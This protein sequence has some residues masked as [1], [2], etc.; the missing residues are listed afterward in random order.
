MAVGIA[1]AGVA[2]KPRGDFRAEAATNAVISLAR[3]EYESL[4]IVVA[5]RGDKPLTGVKVEL[6]DNMGLFAAS[7]V[8]VSVM[9]YVR[10]NEPAAYM[11]RDFDGKVRWPERTWYPD[12]ILDFKACA[13]VEKGDVQSFW[14]RVKCPAGQ[15]AGTY[16]GTLRVSNAD[17]GSLAVPFTVRIRDFD[18]PL[19]SPLDMA[20]CFNPRYFGV[21]S[22]EVRQNPEAP[23]NIWKRHKIAWCDF[24]SEYFITIDDIYLKGTPD[25]DMLERL[26]ARGRLGRFN[27]GY[28]CGFGPGRKAKSDWMGKGRGLRLKAVAEEAKRRGLLDYA[29]FYG[30]DESPKK[31]WPNQARGASA[32]KEMFPHI[33]FLTTIRD[34]SCGTDSILGDVDSFVPN[35]EFWNVTK[36]TEGRRA[37][38]KVWWYICSDPKAPGPNVFVECP[39]VEARLLMGALTQRFKPDG[40]L[41]YALALWRCQKPITTGPFT[42]WLARNREWY[43]GDG[44]MTYCGPD[45]TPIASQHLE[46]FRDG[47]ED[48]W[49]CRILERC[50]AE[51]AKKDEAWARSARAAL[52]VPSELVKSIKQFSIDSDVLNRWRDGMAD[53]IE[54]TTAQKPASPVPN[55]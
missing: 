41:Y 7:N 50:L 16:R 34:D 9:G 1:P 19:T 17:G 46:N 28:W 4:Q 52:A 35:I 21:G 12:P 54:S 37:G 20:M 15:R 30:C 24:L 38:H 8:T 11:A 53:L 33:P 13:D 40:F 31:W 51:R 36:V 22:R 2:I 5:P 44:C 10:V 23:I 18:I 39:P 6:A 45:G 25:W 43:H 32:M 26:K 48:L 29:Y 55:P 42:D 14:V 3:N 47:L 27:L 49:Y